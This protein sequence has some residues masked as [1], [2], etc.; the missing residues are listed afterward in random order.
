MGL[1]QIFTEGNSKKK[2]ELKEGQVDGI[3]GV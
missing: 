2:L 3:I 1:K